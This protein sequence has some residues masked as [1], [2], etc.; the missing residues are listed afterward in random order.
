M[1]V[2][3]KAKGRSVIVIIFTWDETEIVAMGFAKNK[4]L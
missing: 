1:Q 2:Y 3:V 4:G